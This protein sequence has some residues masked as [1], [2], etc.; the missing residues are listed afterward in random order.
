MTSMLYSQRTE[1]ISSKGTPMQPLGNR[2]GFRRGGNVQAECDPRLCEVNLPTDHAK[3]IVR[4]PQRLKGED[5]L[6]T[7]GCALQEHA[8]VSSLLESQFPHKLGGKPA[9]M[10]CSPKG[11]FTSCL[12]PCTGSV[13]VP[14]RRIR[15]E[16]CRLTSS[17][18][19]MPACL[20]MAL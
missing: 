3:C 20:R 13:A 14:P 10:N 12:A 17:G 4:E 18:K 19:K 15:I 5:P 9:N 1:S 2:N 8:L 11:P 7:R 16:S 6:S